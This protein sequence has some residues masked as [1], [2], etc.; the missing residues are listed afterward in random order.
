MPTSW[1]SFFAASPPPPPSGTSDP[2]PS[3]PPTPA[4]DRIQHQP[5]RHEQAASRHLFVTNIGPNTTEHRLEL[6]FS[7][8]GRVE[9]VKLVQRAV[10]F[11]VA[12]VH[13]E[14]IDSAVRAREKLQGSFI[15]GE[16]QKAEIE[17]SHE[18]KAPSAV[19]RVLNL[20]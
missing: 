13:F 5:Q 7:L 18:T 14:H 2:D 9:S 15:G 1:S 10:G 19:L 4:V 20:G 17:F 3:P 16:I 8:F 11:S 12:F 6:Q